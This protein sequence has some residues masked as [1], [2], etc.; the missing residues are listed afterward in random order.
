MAT[1]VKDIGARSAKAARNFNEINNSPACGS[2]TVE[3][4]FD[5]TES[6][7]V[8]VVPPITDRLEHI[9]ARE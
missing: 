8:V 7:T 5:S 3:T 2:I 4:I 1:R 6:T 9:S